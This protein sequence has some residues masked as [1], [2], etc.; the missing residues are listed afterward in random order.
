M[1]RI[2]FALI[3]CAGFIGANAQQPMTAS[4]AANTNADTSYLT[5]KLTGFYD[6]LSFQAVQTKTSGEVAGYAVLQASIDGSN[7]VD[8]SAD[9]LTL[10]DVAVNTKMWTLTNSPYTHYRI[11]MRTS[12]GVSAPK[13]YYVA[14]KR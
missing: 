13:G 1:K 9:S 2:L 4:K 8:I 3:L 6:V 10:A 7:Y 11:A 5:V 14:R 12:N